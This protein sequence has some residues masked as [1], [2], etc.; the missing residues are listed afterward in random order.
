MR[1]VSSIRRKIVATVDGSIN[2][3]VTLNL[4]NKAAALKMAAEHLGLFEQGAVKSV[5][6]QEALQAREQALQGL[7]AQMAQIRARHAQGALVVP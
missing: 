3:E 2:V 4:W 1:A 7:R 6:I 5:E